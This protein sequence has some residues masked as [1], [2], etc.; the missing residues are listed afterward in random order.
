M[1]KGK[2]SSASD[3]AYEH[4]SAPLSSLKDPASF[5]PPPKHIKYHGAAAAS[6]SSSSMPADSSRF[7]APRASDEEASRS[8]SGP[9]K[10]D[11][12]GLNTAH[13]PTPT[14][15][16][17]HASSPSTTAPAKPK[18][19][20]PPRLPPRQNEYPDAHTPAPPPPYSE[21]AEDNAV[22]QSHLNQ[23]AL[24]RLGG[25]G[26]SVPG[27]DI[28]RNAP[29]PV[30]PR[31]N[32]SPAPTPAPAPP[33][34]TEPNRKPQLNELQPGFARMPTPPAEAP[35]L[36]TTWA[37]KQAA[38][39]TASNLRDSPSKATLSDAR[40]AASTANNFRQRH[41]EQAAAGWRT[42]SGLNQKHGITN[43]VG[44]RASSSSTPPP[45][46]SPTHGGVGK[47]PPPPPPIPLGSK[48]KF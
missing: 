29:P 24:S 31:Q 10:V 32:P 26:I 41:G 22:S 14:F 34:A 23:G 4:Q 36:G 45:P 5:A 25:A 39:K 11:T 9:Y 16:P 46:Q 15:R 8:S 35:K 44:S 2:S 40:S 30:P 12:T 37:E 19:S 1:G 13:L 21:T 28:G 6:T 27:F 33:A 48:P 20:L 42:A 7:G 18:P 3:A 17:D 43:K 38:L 47:K